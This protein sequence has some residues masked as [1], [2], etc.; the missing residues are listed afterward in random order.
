MVKI[1]DISGSKP[2]E[3]SVPEEQVQEAVQSGKYTL[4]QG[5]VPV[6]SPD[7][8]EGSVPSD[9]LNAALEQ[10]YKYATPEASKQ[11]RFNTPS[12]AIKSV[13]EG[14][15]KGYLGPGAAL[16]ERSSKANLDDIRARAEVNPGLHAL[17]ETGGFLASM[18]TGTGEARALEAASTALTK[19]LAKRAAVEGAMYAA[20]DEASKL[21]TEDP[22]QSAQ[23][24]LAHIGTG[25]ILGGV[26]GK[27]ADKLSQAEHTRI[28]KFIDDFKTRMQEH[29]ELP[30]GVPNLESLPPGARAA[31][32]LLKKGASKLSGAAVGAA[33]GHATGIPFGGTIGAL[34]GKEVGETA[35]PALAKS[36]FQNPT[37]AQA[38][39]ASTEYA[40]SVSK[41]QTLL[42]KAAESVFKVSSDPLS[43]SLFPTEKQ[44]DKIKEHLEE[45][46]NNPEP[47][48]NASKPIAHYMPENAS[49]L[50]ETVARITSFLG[51][52]KPSTD[53]TSM[54][55]PNRQPNA[56]EEAQYNRALDIAEQPL[57]VAHHIKQG[58]LTPFDIQAGQAMYPQLMDAL[59]VKMLGSMTKH[60]SG[61]QSIPYKTVLALSLFLGQPLDSSTMPQDV[62]ANQ[63][64][65]NPPQ[66]PPDA[67][68][69][70]RTQ[71]KGTTAA[72]SKALT[73]FPQSTALPG[74]AREM[75]RQSPDRK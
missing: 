33:A 2:V 5:E 4:P 53:K 13:I 14:A 51:T 18:L 21:I 29:I 12:N 43:E 57:I 44:K 39:R 41:G 38:F 45:I 71:T 23:S 74:Q 65:Y 37:F 34:L 64:V 75:N 62:L 63:G 47:L 20:G 32:A 70:K 69:A 61:D 15:A 68:N 17:G 48:F 50:G 67:S 72:Q 25:A 59:R 60:L 35:L 58:S 7:G 9:Q 36:L 6:I 73:N 56:V 27:A 31:D 16:V 8:Q 55:G 42:N 10:G 11:A 40:Y 54:L 49:A 3:G 46:Q 22:H 19:S 66:P 24:A 30:G 26:L 28:G 52:V 1:F